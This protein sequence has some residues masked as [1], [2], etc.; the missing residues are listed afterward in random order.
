L[1]VCHNPKGY[2]YFR[3][4]TSLLLFGVVC[5]YNLI[6]APCSFYKIASIAQ[7]V[8]GK[9]ETASFKELKSS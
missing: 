6:V 4:I 1:H 9:E 8:I 7:G 5:D 3:E 2:G